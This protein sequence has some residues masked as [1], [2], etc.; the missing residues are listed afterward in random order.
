MSKIIF[1]INIQIAGYIIIVTIVTKTIKKGSL[2]LYVIIIQ[3]NKKIFEIQNAATNL[4][5][6]NSLYYCKDEAEKVI[7]MP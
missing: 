7:E 5:P 6:L 4:F 2:S 1:Q 3:I